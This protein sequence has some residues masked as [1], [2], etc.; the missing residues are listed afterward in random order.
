MKCLFQ[1]VCV[2]VVPAVAIA[3]W[4]AG[5]P[6]PMPVWSDNSTP[7]LRTAS[8]T[9]QV[10]SEQTDPILETRT[11]KHDAQILIQQ[12]KRFQ[13]L[14]SERSPRVDDVKAALES[15][16]NSRMSY[17]WKIGTIKLFAIDQNM[18][19]LAEQLADRGV[20]DTETKDSFATRILKE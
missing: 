19:Q 12:V 6:S 2:L 11:F 16:L 7:A 5:S 13:A 1:K 20:I 4:A 8:T 3:W 9:V 14:A 18:I 10:D 17:G 15:Y